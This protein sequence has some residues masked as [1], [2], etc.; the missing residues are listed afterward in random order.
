MSTRAKVTL[1]LGSGLLLLWFSACH[2]SGVGRP[3]WAWYHWQQ[4]WQPADSLLSW[5]DPKAEAVWY[6]RFFDIDAPAGTASAVPV[7]RLEWGKPLPDTLVAAVFLTT[8]ALAA[9]P[10]D[11]LPSLAQKTWRLMTQMAEAANVH[12]AEVQIDCDWT[13]SLRD[14]YFSF[15]SAFRQMLPA[16]CALSATIR[17]HQ[18]KWAERTGIPPVDRGMLMVYNTGDVRTPTTRNSILE[19]EVLRQ[20]LSGFDTYPLPLDVVWPLFEW[21]VVFRDGRFVRLISPLSDTDLRD[22]T[23]FAQAEDHRFAVRQSTYL[24]GHYLYA[25]DTIRLEAVPFDTLLLAARLL[26][27]AMP[28]PPARV[29]FYHL[30]ELV[31][32]NWTHDQ[33]RR[34]VEAMAH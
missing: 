26:H 33:L 13:P 2:P 22:T 32:Q 12:L 34:I 25:G 11:S 19:T 30:D 15:L 29:A 9:V 20:Y 31:P 10:A 24:K 18:V 28:R 7:S 23:R 14:K 5:A 3:R 16:S 17:L 1:T 21:G 4:R 6:V 8:R 27:R